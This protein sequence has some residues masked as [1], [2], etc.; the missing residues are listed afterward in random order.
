MVYAPMI[1]ESGGGT[2]TTYTDG[3]TWSYSNAS[4]EWGGCY[5]T[6][7]IVQVTLRIKSLV[8]G[9]ASNPPLIQINNLPYRPDQTTGQNAFRFTTMPIWQKYNKETPGYVQDNATLSQ[10]GLRISVANPNIA[11]DDLLDINFSYIS[12]E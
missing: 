9:S 7:R 10:N 4:Y 5:K 6:G 1:N 8:A 3:S 12:K 2:E 11:V